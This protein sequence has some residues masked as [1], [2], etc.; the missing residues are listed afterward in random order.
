MNLKLNAQLSD[1]RV[2][3]LADLFDNLGLIR[4][5]KAQWR[6]QMNNTMKRRHAVLQCL[7]HVLN[8]HNVT[9]NQC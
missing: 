9:T 2:L 8:K 3:Y 7:T 6:R 1:Y 5:D 4:L